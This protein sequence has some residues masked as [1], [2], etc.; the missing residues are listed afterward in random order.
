MSWL[1]PITVK[2]TDLLIKREEEAIGYHLPWLAA[3]FA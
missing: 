2:R 1:L 3:D